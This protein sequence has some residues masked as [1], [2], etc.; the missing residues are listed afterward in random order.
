MLNKALIGTVL[1]FV[2]VL[3]NGTDPTAAGSLAMQ[4]TRPVPAEPRGII[5]TAV[6]VSGETGDELREEFHQTYPLSAT[7]RISLENINGGVQIK[8]VSYTHLRAHE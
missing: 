4:E 6:P 1:M 2:A 8:A 7:G 5:T 3:I